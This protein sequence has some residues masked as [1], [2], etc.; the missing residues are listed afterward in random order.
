MAD[1]ITVGQ[2]QFTRAAPVDRAAG[3]LGWIS[4]SIGVVRVDGLAVRR[5]RDGRLTLSFPRGRGKRQPVRPVDDRARR[6]IER[7]VLDALGY[8]TEA[9]P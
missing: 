1:E 6:E 9:A 8:P 7:Q 3:L 2:V 5:T 4:C